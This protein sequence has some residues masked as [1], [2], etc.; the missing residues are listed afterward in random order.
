MKNEGLKEV[1]K[2]LLTLANLVLVVFFL[3]NYL[4]R[5]EHS[6]VGIILS[7]YAVGMLYYT[8]YTTINKGDNDA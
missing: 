2:S 1:G 3:N 6:I 7:L 4:Q 5:D 8:G